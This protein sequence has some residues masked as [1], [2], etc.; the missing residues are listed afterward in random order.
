[1]EGRTVSVERVLRLLAEGEIELHGS[2]PWSSNYTFLVSVSDGDLAVMA[3][4]KPT[5]GER[6][7]WDFPEG[8]L[9]LREMAAYVV[10]E[11]LGWQL[12][13]PTVLRDGP[14]GSGAVQLYIDADAQEHY[15][16]F[17]PHHPREAQQI[18][19][20]DAVV[21]NADRKAGHCLIDAQGHIWAIDHGVCFSP[22]P[23]LRSVIWD[24]AGQPIPPDLLQ[25]LGSL[26]T[27]LGQDG[28]LTR[29]LAR[30][31]DSEEISALQ[32]RLDD[33][34]QRGHLPLPGPQ[35]HYPWPLV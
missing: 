30:L 13:P 15:F 31:L 1:M 17:G 34:I 4:Y 19:L 23:K 2:F 32:R 5:R 21:N 8:T 28:E 3:V 35:R 10:S 25:D 26:Q 12:V 20:F 29:V 16:T 9:A 14:H 18:A 7:L 11:A 22:E 27:R 6:P 33:L 24:Y